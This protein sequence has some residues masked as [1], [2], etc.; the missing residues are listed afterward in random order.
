MLLLFILNAI[1]YKSRIF[2]SIFPYL[3]VLILC[4][5]LGDTIR[6]A[7][8][9]DY[10]GQK[11]VVMDHF[12]TTN[13]SAYVI[14]DEVQ[15]RLGEYYNGFG[16]KSETRFLKFDDF[17]F[18]TLDKKREKYVLLNSYTQQLSNLS[19]EDLPYYT[20]TNDSSKF[21]YRNELHHIFIFK[22]DQ[23][24]NPTSII[25]YE[26]SFENVQDSTNYF[27]NSISNQK[28]Y[29]GE[30]SN[31][32]E[33]FSNPFK[34]SIDS[35]HFKPNQHLLIQLKLAFWKDQPSKAYV[36]ISIDENEKPYIYESYPIDHYV[37]A[38]SNWNN[39][40]MSVLLDSNK[41]HPGSILKVYIWNPEKKEMYMDDFSVKLS[42]VQ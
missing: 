13:K 15:K 6:W 28:K 12:I 41:F 22:M 35:A 30:Y 18:D 36:V 42:L 7:N 5:K 21:I 34:Y 37:K 32:I 9:L 39:V 25:N 20:L 38:F 14:T 24:A 11:K 27:K 4:F 40:K 1:L 8:Q 19:Q 16:I 33:E 3:F 26:T 10:E 29:A 31:W 17:K 23:F 2:N